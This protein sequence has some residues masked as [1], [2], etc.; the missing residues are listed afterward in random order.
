ML[1]KLYLTEG[2]G[3]IVVSKLGYHYRRHRQNVITRHGQLKSKK[4]N[5]N[6]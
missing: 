1:I 5:E 3:D 4:I 6:K 2:S